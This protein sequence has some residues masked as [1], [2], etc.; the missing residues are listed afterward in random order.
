MQEA[1]LPMLMKTNPK[2]EQDIR[3]VLKK[4]VQEE[5]QDISHPDK[6]INQVKRQDY[7]VENASKIPTQIFLG[8]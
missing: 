3:T 6:E 2:I 4:E 5:M 7:P 8:V 1:M